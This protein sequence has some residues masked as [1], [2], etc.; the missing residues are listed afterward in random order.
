MA[1]AI[2]GLDAI[3]GLTVSG[4]EITEVL[5]AL[6]GGGFPEPGVWRGVSDI[7]VVEVKPV[8]NKDDEIWAVDVQMTGKDANERSINWRIRLILSEGETTGS[9]MTSF[10]YAWG[11]V[12]GYFTH[13]EMDDKARKIG[14]T[15][16]KNP[17]GKDALTNTIK[18]LDKLSKGNLAVRYRKN[19]NGYPSIQ[20]IDKEEDL[21]AFEEKLTSLSLEEAEA[22]RV[23]ATSPIKK[24]AGK[25]RGKV[26]EDDDDFGGSDDDSDSEN[27]GSD[28]TESGD[29]EADDDDW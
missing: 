14:L 22:L 13:F 5:S 20:P 2:K 15:A 25:R 26:E 19:D 8:S 23:L 28:D 6:N 1:N 9:K 24:G 7:S 29:N 16:A 3:K 27:T 21:D 12:L 18:A 11:M 4:P 10:A 17:S